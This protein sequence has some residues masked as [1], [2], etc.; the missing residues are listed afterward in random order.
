M[1]CFFKMSFGQ[2]DMES[3]RILSPET[4]DLVVLY[5][6]HLFY[7]GFL[8]PLPMPMFLGP[9]LCFPLHYS[10]PKAP[11]FKALRP[12]LSHCTRFHLSHHLYELSR[13]FPWMA[14]RLK[15]CYHTVYLVMLRANPKHVANH[16]CPRK[17]LSEEA[18]HAK[19][20]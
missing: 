3:Y 20:V 15:L 4:G 5:F 9:G 17:G 8:T 6:M 14:G 18:F 10:T 16:H 13:S 11:C 19:C 1:K 12:L 2:R 7:Q